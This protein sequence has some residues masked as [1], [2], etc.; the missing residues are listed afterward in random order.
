MTVNR[1]VNRAARMYNILQHV[2]IPT[3]DKLEETFEGKRGT[4]PDG[5]Q[6]QVGTQLVK[7]K[8]TRDTLM[9]CEDLLDYD[10]EDMAELL[11]GGGNPHTTL[12]EQLEYFKNL[13]RLTV[14][15][16]VWSC[17]LSYSPL[18]AVI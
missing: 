18:T 1:D 14:S 11:D 3:V 5:E 7:Q 9:V 17:R 6:I 2:V 16:S 4:V 12:N 13:L 8:A 10:Y 15:C